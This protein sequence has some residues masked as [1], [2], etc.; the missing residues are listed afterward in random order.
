M[1]G[2][3]R[4]SRYLSR[5]LLIEIAGSRGFATVRRDGLI[6]SAARQRAVD[7]VDGVL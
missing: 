6:L 4:P 2:L 5:N 3:S 1:A 7:H